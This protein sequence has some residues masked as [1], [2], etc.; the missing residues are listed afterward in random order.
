MSKIE[1]VTKWRG[2]IGKWNTDSSN[3]AT[4]VKPQ[5]GEQPFGLC[6]SNC[7]LSEG[8]I[9]FEI[10]QSSGVVDGRVVLGYRSPT[11]DYFIIGVG[12]YGKAYT[13]SHFSLSGGGWK[14]IMGVGDPA[15]L[16]ANEKYEV[17]VKLN[18]KSIVLEVNGVVV[19]NHSLASSIPYG[20]IGLFA[21]GEHERNFSSIS[22]S[23]AAKDEDQIVVLVHGI[24][25]H[26]EWQSMLKR[27]FSQVGITVALT[28]YGY[29]D[30]IRFL[31]PIQSFRAEALN[32]LRQLM[33]DVRANHPRAKISLLAHSFGTYL[34]SRFIQ[35]ETNFP[36]HRI[37]FCGSVV[38]YDFPFEQ[39]RHRFTGPVINEVSSRDPWPLAAEGLSFGYGTAGTRGF[40]MPSVTDRWHSGF[41]HSQYLQQSF[42]RK[43]WLPFF[44]TGII[45]ESDDDASRPPIWLRLFGLIT[46]KFAILGMLGALYFL[47]PYIWIEDRT[48]SA[49]QASCQDIRKSTAGQWRTANLKGGDQI[50]THYVIVRSITEFR[51]YPWLNRLFAQTKAFQLSRQFPT[52]SFDTMHTTRVS[53]GNNMQAIVL[54]SGLAN[55]ERACEIRQQAATCGVSENA[56]VYQLGNQA[57]ACR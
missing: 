42:C 20:Q 11:E 7:S 8:E 5:V 29:F 54:A 6:V 25:T 9:A 4:Y 18:Q 12:G 30:L 28:N 1:L 55:K 56:Y 47:F 10:L 37:A 31:L 49:N 15:N 43:Y 27:E 34:V 45:V 52:L 35:E 13:L 48:P 57:L 44:S 38:R 53:G 41:G 24:R 39:L 3:S 17:K 32:R 16:P 36:I 2:I 14:E 19:L 50:G 40:N 26:A 33:N 51:D 22:V 46:N 21:W 23:R